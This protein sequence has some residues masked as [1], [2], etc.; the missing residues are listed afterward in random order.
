[1]SDAPTAARAAAIPERPT[2]V[3][4]VDD[5]EQI[6]RVLR[7]ILRTRKYHVVE[8]ETGE[9]ALIAAIDQRLLSRFGLNDMVLTR[10]EDGA[11]HAADLLDRKSVV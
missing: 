9:K 5:E 10:P 2:T 4:V 3:L 6:R 8:A 1:M 11:Q 7:S